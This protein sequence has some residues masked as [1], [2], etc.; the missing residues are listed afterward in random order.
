MPR[1]FHVPRKVALVLAVLAAVLAIPTSAQAAPA[2]HAQPAAAH[3]TS[4]AVSTASTAAST[5]RTSGNSALFG[6][7][8][9]PGINAIAGLLGFCSS[10]E[11]ILS[12]LNNICSP[13]LPEP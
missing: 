5:S 3:H 13:S 10:G 9:V 12:P 8:S 1:L 7:C 6:P 11:N 4:A 2:A